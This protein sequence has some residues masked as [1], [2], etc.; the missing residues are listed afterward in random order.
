MKTTIGFPTLGDLIKFIY[1]AFG[2]LARKRGLEN[3][4]DE[5]EKKSLQTALARLANEECDI[6]EKVKS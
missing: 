5:T 2:V 4:I 1:D 6:N 3:E